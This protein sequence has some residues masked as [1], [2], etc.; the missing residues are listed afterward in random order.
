MKEVRVLALL[1]MLVPAAPLMAQQGPEP[2]LGPPEVVVKLQPQGAEAPRKLL[3]G[4][5][6]IGVCKQ[7]AVCGDHFTVVWV[8]NRNAG[9]LIRVRFDDPDAAGE[10]F[11]KTDFTVDDVGVPNRVTVKVRSDNPDC[12]DKTAFFYTVSCEGG[13]EGN[14]GKVQPVDPG[15]M[16]D[17][18]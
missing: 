16:I 1:A 11:D 12:P 4:P 3:I 17:G 8:G 13:A 15:A 7:S 14:C 18:G 2:N 9:E 6:G 10:C 5:R